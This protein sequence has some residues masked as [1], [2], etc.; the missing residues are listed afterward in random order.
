MPQTNDDKETQNLEEHLANLRATE[1]KMQALQ[2]ELEDLI[3]E[4]GEV[5]LAALKLVDELKMS[6]IK[7]YIQTN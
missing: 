6:K 1:E 2:K 5:R 4:G 7:N 3:K